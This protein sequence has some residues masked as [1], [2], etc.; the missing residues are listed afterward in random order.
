MKPRTLFTHLLTATLAFQICLPSLAQNASSKPARGVVTL[1]ESSQY[2]TATNK[3]QRF[4]DYVELT[5]DDA[6][7]PLTLKL[8]NG[9]NMSRG[10][11]WIRV[12]IG[13]KT[14]FTENNVIN[15]SEIPLTVTGLIGGGT[16]Q[17]IVEAGGIPGSTLS[18][19]LLGARIAPVLQGVKPDKTGTGVTITLTGSHFGAVATTNKVSIGG[20]NAEIKSASETSLDVVV[21]DNA[22]AGDNKVTVTTAGAT[23]NALNVTVIQPPV[24]DNLDLMSGPPG[25]EMTITGKNFSDK[26]S[27]NVVTIAGAQAEITYASANSL[28]VIIPEVF[29]PQYAVPVTVEVNGVKS[30]N[31]LTMDIYNRVY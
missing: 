22:K 11:N 28:T 1:G 16:T 31:S 30:K 15:K 26:V 14:L 20:I 18:W 27:E 6:T 9:N 21:P 29:N 12:S 5:A 3:P 2:S 8:I 13:G 23:S 17:I 10:F 25:Q 24:L 19:K 7:L 4:M